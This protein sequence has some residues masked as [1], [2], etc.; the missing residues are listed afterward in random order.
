MVCHILCEFRGKIRK[1]H[2]RNPKKLHLEELGFCDL[3]QSKK[4]LTRYDGP[5]L[6]E[7]WYLSPGS[8][9][10]YAARCQVYWRFDTDEMAFAST[11]IRYHTHEQIHVQNTKESIDWHINIYWHHLG[12]VPDICSKQLPILHWINQSPI[13]KIYFTEVNSIFAFQKLVTCRSH[14]STN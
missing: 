3:G 12:G 9:V 6:V 13:S 1:V 11:L 5:T 7:P 8:Y 4:T 14:I 10:F 2:Y